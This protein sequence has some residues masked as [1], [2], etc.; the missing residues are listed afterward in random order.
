MIVSLAAVNC[1]PNPKKVCFGD[2]FLTFKKVFFTEILEA[3]PEA[4]GIFT[5]VPLRCV[6]SSDH[7]FKNCVAKI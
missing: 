7:L 4:V 5:P 2:P 6:I 3:I 1:A